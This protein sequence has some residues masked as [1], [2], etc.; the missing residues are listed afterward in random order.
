MGSV[1]SLPD[2]QTDPNECTADKVQRKQERVGRAG[3]LQKTA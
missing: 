1:G 2:C 3:A